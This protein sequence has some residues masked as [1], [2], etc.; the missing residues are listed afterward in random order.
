MMFPLFRVEGAGRGDAGG[1]VGTVTRTTHGRES[2][3]G[4]GAVGYLKIGSRMVEGRWHARGASWEFVPDAPDLMEVVLAHP[5]SEAFDGYW[6]ERA[7]LVLDETRRWSKATFQPTSAMRMHGPGVVLFRPD[8]ATS[9]AAIPAV[10]GA[11]VDSQTSGAEVIPGGWDH[12]HCAICWE[13]IGAG[14]QAEG[15]VSNQR[16]W[17]CSPCYGAF[18]E[19]RS[20]DFIPSPSEKG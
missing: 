1:V 19:L 18:V 8:D 6:G 16:T 12:E 3:I 4:D 13:T 7:E 10:G 17:V 11:S 15:Y 9:L 20:L 14:G 2:W 5:E